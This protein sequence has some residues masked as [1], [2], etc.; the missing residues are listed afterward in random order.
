MPDNGLH[1]RLCMVCQ[2]IDGIPGI[3][4]VSYN[5][6]V[7]CVSKVHMVLCRILSVCGIAVSRFP[8]NDRWDRLHGLGLQ[9]KFLFDWIFLETKRRTILGFFSSCVAH[10]LN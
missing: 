2:C 3:L 10:K 9:A 7:I 8:P 5:M 6:H 4:P 1:C